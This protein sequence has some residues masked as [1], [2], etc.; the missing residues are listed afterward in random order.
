MSADFVTPSPAAFHGRVTQTRVLHSEWLKLSTIRSTYITAALTLV[1][2]IGL[3]IVTCWGQSDHYAWMAPDLKA[4]WDPAGWS[5]I[6][7]TFSQLSIGVLGVLTV[8]GEY[9]S[10]MIRATLGAVPERWPVLEAKAAV[11]GAA[12]LVLSTIGCLAAFYAGQTMFA[13]KHIGTTLSAPGV[14]RE[15]FGTAF[16]VTLVGLFGIALGAL[17][18]STPGGISCLLGIITILPLVARG[19]PE[20]WYNALAPYLPS[21]AGTDITRLYHTPH[22]LYPWPGFGLFALYVAGTFAVAT[23]LLKRRDA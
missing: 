20:N 4:R 17:V 18:R 16:Y 1:V 9:T 12:A 5:Q 14:A 13:G 7:F 2:T 6:G 19:L 3:A 11:F 21:N 10:G 8:T 15:I 23:V 22:T